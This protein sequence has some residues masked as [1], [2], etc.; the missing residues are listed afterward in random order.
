M[1]DMAFVRENA[2]RVRKAIADKFEKRANLDEVLRL[3]KECRDVLGRTEALRNEANASSKK[4]AEMKKASQ[5]ASEFISSTRE[6]GD[7]IHELEEHPARSEM[8]IINPIF[9]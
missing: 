2:E 6:L 4:I 3:D 7:R 1:L 8:A 9:F 5:D